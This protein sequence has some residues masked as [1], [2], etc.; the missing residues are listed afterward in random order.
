MILVQMTAQ[1]PTTGAP[2]G[3]TVSFYAQYQTVL[4]LLVRLNIITG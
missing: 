3:V 1:S 2:R 4:G